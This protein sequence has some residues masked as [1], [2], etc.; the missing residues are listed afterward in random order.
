MLENFRG[1]RKFSIE[2][3]CSNRGIDSRQACP[4][5]RRR[6]AKHVLSQVEGHAKFE[7]RDEF[8]GRNSSLLFSD[9]AALAPL[10]EIFRVS[11]AALPRWDLRGYKSVAWPRAY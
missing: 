3:K 7:G 2:L 8:S 1:L 11:V 6:G 4:E 9:F 5:Q 10:R